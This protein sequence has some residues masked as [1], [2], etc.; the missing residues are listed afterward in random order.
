[1]VQREI[2]HAR[3]AQREQEAI[4]REQRQYVLDQREESLVNRTRLYG[5]AIQYALTSMP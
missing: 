2:A 4:A 3:Q 1:M 5:Q